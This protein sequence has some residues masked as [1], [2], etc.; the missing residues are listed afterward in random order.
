MFNSKKK[1]LQKRAQYIQYSLN[2]S[3]LWG[4]SRLLL[5]SGLIFYFYINQKKAL[6]EKYYS[7]QVNSKLLFGKEESHKQYLDDLYLLI[8]NHKF[9]ELLFE[10]PRSIKE[11]HD[12]EISK[13]ENDN[14]YKF[15]S[16]VYRS[17]LKNYN[18]DLAFIKEYLVSSVD[19]SLI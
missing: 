2:W 10:E 16:Y 17:I 19:K 12:D 18:I 11:R 13:F 15:P 7:N 8:L 6:T 9:I 14:N 1:Q 3:F 5:T 4:V